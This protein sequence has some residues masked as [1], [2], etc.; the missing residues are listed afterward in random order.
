MCVY[1]FSLAGLSLGRRCGVCVYMSS[2]WLASRWAVGVECVYVCFLTG[3]PLVGPYVWSVCMYAFSLAGLSLGRRCGVC[4]CMS[5]HWLA[6]LCAV[7]V[8]YVCVCVFSLAG[9]SLGCRCAV[10]V[11]SFSL[12][13]FKN[14]FF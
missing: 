3:W 14:S 9:L 6:S 13:S 12:H 7:G 8:E 4:V 11:H 2:H 1:V 5:S 10:C